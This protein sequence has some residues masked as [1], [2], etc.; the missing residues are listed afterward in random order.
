MKSFEHEATVKSFFPDICGAVIVFIYSLFSTK[1][2][3][4]VF[5]DALKVFLGILIFFQFGLALITD[6]LCYHKISTRIKSFYTSKST[7]TERTHLFDEI[8]QYPFF[9]ALMTFFYFFVGSCI[10]AYYLYAG[11][12]QPLNITGLF[13]IEALFGTYFTSIFAYTF[14]SKIVSKIGIDI[15]NAG[16]EKDYVMKKKFFGIRFNMKVLLFVALPCIF[17]CIINC[18]VLIA[19]Y[20]PFEVSSIIGNGDMQTNRMLNTI[21]INSIVMFLSILFFYNDINAKNTRMTEVLSTITTDFSKITPIETDISDE[22]SFNHYLANQIISMLRGILFQTEQFGKTIAESSSDLMRIANETEST[23]VEQSTGIKKIVSTMENATNLSHNIE[24]RIIEVTEIAKQ[25]VEK[26]NTGSELL[27][28][29]LSSISAIADSNEVT[30]QGIKNL[31]NKINQIWEI[32]NII[33]SISDQTK[34]IAFNAELEAT[35][36]IGESKNF[37]NVA[38]EIRRLANS[39]MDSTREIKAKISAV[40]KSSEQLIKASQESTDLI[41][42]ETELSESLENKFTNINNSARYN[43][44][45]SNEI[46]YL[47][48]QQTKAFDQ[49]V[50]TLHQIST[51]VQ[52]F[53]KSTRSLIETSRN[54]QENVNL[55]ESASISDHNTEENEGMEA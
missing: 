32:A 39:T 48:E 52:G 4:E 13:I 18:A 33:D 19:G 3:I 40:Q 27:S 23:S 12:N 7:V 35:T 24:N 50:N 6:H 38:N 20:Y 28:K 37:K 53:S 25:T 42:K 21:L 1:F 51:S 34:I 26:V 2:S 5:L 22:F 31:N 36:E 17:T 45:S 46:K 9:T 47:V 41:R 10:I 8:I 44:T 30:I 15:I 16:I 55:I 14:C 43:S 54:L 49:I 11:L 29:S